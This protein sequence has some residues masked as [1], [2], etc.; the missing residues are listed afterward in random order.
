M[1]HKSESKSRGFESPALAEA[2][3]YEAFAN[4]DSQGMS[5]VW[6]SSDCAYCIHPGGNPLVGYASVQASWQ[7]MFNGGQ[8]VNLFYRV[9][10]SEVKGDMAIHL[11]EE[12]ISAMDGS[13]HGRVMATNCYLKTDGGWWLLCH[14]GSPMV[15]LKGDRSER[16]THL[17]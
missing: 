7:Q 12:E 13:R 4:I 10:K 2:F 5:Q 6:L 3:F 9:V 8:P 1:M 15:T 14:H 17:H 16:S 11:V